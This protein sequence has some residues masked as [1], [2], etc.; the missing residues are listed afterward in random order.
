MPY[1]GDM[2]TE[3]QIRANTRFEHKAYSKITVRLR[4][5][6]QNGIT[7][8]TVQAAADAVGMSV[9]EYIIEAVREKIAR[10]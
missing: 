2:A 9:N 3:A 8:E 5:D 7:R 6:G 1:H 10:T 4:K